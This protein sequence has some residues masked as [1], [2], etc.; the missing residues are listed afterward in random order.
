MFLVSP[1]QLFGLGNDLQPGFDLAH[2][3]MGRGEQAEIADLIPTDT[4]RR[5]LGRVLTHERD[6]GLFGT[7]LHHRPAPQDQAV[8]APIAQVVPIGELEDRIGVRPHR[9][10]VAEKFFEPGTREVVHVRCEIRLVHLASASE[11]RDAGALR[12]LREAHD[13]EDRRKVGKGRHLRVVNVVHRLGSMLARVVQIENRLK[14]GV[15][16]GERARV[17]GRDASQTVTGEANDGIRQ[18]LGYAP[19]L[20]GQSPHR[21]IVAAHKG[22]DELATECCDERLRLPQ[23]LAESAGTAVGGAGLRS[24]VPLHSDQ[25]RAD[26]DLKR[27]V[28]ADPAQGLPGALP[29]PPTPESGAGSPRRWPIGQRHV[30]R[31]S[32]STRRRARS[33]GLP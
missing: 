32:A 4:E 14:L 21:G 3:R 30:R 31:P 22:V 23:P 9:R 29:A 18:T 27:R 17:H 26:R 28:P 1:K 8:Q 19:S 2:L 7:L 33:D 11:R 10:G 20:V 15:G 5:A 16:L 12:L 24:G 6:A 25:G 13:P